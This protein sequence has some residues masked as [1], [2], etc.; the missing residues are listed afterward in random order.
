[1]K[2]MILAAALLALATPVLAVNK[3]IIKGHLTWQSDPCPPGTALDDSQEQDISTTEN[4]IYPDPAY[5]MAFKTAQAI[6][7]TYLSYQRCKDEAPG[8]CE[9]FLQ[10]FTEELGPR[11]KESAE[12]MTRIAEN[13]AAVYL[14][15]RH[16]DDLNEMMQLMQASA[17]LQRRV[18]QLQQ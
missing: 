12:N 17:D 4:R 5:E 1:M 13:P 7:R 3:C 2:H 18:L 15:E 11:L 16:Q 8:G 10:R 14:L 9:Q 6:E